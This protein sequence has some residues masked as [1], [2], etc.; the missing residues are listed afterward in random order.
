FIFVL[1]N[2]LSAF[3]GALKIDRPFLWV[4]ALSIATIPLLAKAESWQAFTRS[5]VAGWMLLHLTICT[6]SLLWSTRSHLILDLYRGVLLDSVIALL[7]VL[8]LSSPTPVRRA[9]AAVAACVIL[10]SI[11]NVYDLINPGTFSTGVGRAAGLY[12]NSNSSA[13]AIGLGV[14]LSLDLVPRKWRAL[15][16]IIAGGGVILTFS[17][18]GILGFAFIVLVM[19]L[20]NRVSARSLVLAFATIVVCSELLIVSSTKGRRLQEIARVVVTSGVLD[21]LVNV[22]K[23]AQGADASAI[24]RVEVVRRGWLLF[25]SHPLRGAGFGATT[26]WTI[27]QSTHNIYVRQLAEFGMIG[28]ILYPLLLY[29]SVLG[30]QRGERALALMFVGFLLMNGLFSHNVLEER[31]YLVAYVLMAAIAWESLRR[32]V[33]ERTV[34]GR[35]VAN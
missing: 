23:T 20:T 32:E 25:E 10:G 8:L 16:M 29:A 27:K 31:H 1:Y 15:F 2:G 28:F 18:A 34:H 35:I 30:A 13:S 7:L 22:S 5:P 9:R 14:I 4:M 26:E 19:V 24:T 17:R 6:V 21:R 33:A 12:V 3:L 11:L